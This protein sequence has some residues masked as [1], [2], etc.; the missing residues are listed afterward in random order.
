MTA[1]DISEDLISI[2]DTY[3]EMGLNS[4]TGTMESERQQKESRQET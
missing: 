3:K 2:E 1:G 4:K